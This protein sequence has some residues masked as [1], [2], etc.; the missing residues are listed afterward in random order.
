MLRNSGDIRTDHAGQ[1]ANTALF[2]VEF[3]DNEQSTR[4]SHRLENLGPSR[5]VSL[6]R[7]IHGFR[8]CKNL[9]GILAK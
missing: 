6:A 1:F 7:F 8:L 4:M 5:Q 9:F 2:L 3:F